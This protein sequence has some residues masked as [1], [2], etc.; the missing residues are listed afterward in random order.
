MGKI[1]EKLAGLFSYM[2]DMF[3][4]Y[5]VTTVT[6]IVGT[7]L[8]MAGTLISV[9]YYSA[10]FPMSQEQR[11]WWGE[12][13]SQGGFT[14]VVYL[15]VAF[16]LEGILWKGKKVVKN[17]L[18]AVFG[19]WSVFFLAVTYDSVIL[20]KQF[21][22]VH[23]AIGDKRCT[24]ILFAYII[25]FV[26]LCLYVYYCNHSE[27]SFSE[28][29]FRIFS[30]IFLKGVV[31][32]VICIGYL[33][34]SGIIIVLLTDEFEEF[35]IP[36]L[37]AITGLYLVMAVL[38]CISQAGESVMRFMDVLVRKV[39]LIIC[40]AAYLIIYIYMIKIVI[41]WE[42]PSN[43]VFSI[44][45]VLFAVSVPLTYM[46]TAVKESTF[47]YKAAYYSPLLFIP[48][49]CLQA[50]SMGMRIAQHGVTPSR[51]MG[52]V[53]VLFEI[54]YIVWYF[55]KKGRMETMLLVMVA[56]A[57]ISVFIPGIN[58]ISLSRIIQNNTLRNA[59][60]DDY[61]QLSANQLSRAKSAFDYL[62]D[63]DH[64]DEF[65][66]KNYTEAEAETI[67]QMSDYYTGQSNSGKQQTEWVRYYDYDSV[68]L[69]V[70]DYSSIM[71]FSAEVE[72]DWPEGG[73]RYLPVD[74]TDVLACPQYI[75]GY[76]VKEGEPILSFDATDILKTLLEAY[77]V[78]TR[79][80]KDV[81][82]LYLD[83]DD[84]TRIVFSEV[85]LSYD[86]DTEEVLNVNMDG[87]LL[88]K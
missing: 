47:L 33:A 19:I 31:Y 87:Y 41:T 32:S 83:L 76:N 16:L 11:S 84:G 72:H 62:L 22:N 40:L 65:L 70:S 59:I 50:L 80:I 26:C 67:V 78:D 81:S 20:H 68:S 5:P 56:A 36:G 49:V 28:Y 74:C 51:Y 53:Y 60:S 58:A 75:S 66:E 13:F 34:L 12:L 8:F 15:P 64:G 25:I 2:K 46:C 1:R 45:S 85:E 79:T 71:R 48:F 3:R 69:D 23:N 30:G 29:C 61:R 14:A 6:V 88:F 17:I 43:S 21:L 57:L 7:A 86:V 52:L 77:D 10:P 4:N 63:M 54:I 35:I 38:H 44:C 82:Y 42:F 55:V 39:M 18:L 9:F 37:I 27:L 24:M 73:S